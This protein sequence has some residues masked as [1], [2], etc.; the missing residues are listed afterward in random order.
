MHAENCRIASNYSTNLKKKHHWNHLQ[1]HV[2]YCRCERVTPR[3]TINVGTTQM[4]HQLTELLHQTE[5]VWQ[6]A[7]F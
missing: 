2:W 3:L 4:H 7:K 6:G 1:D 5:A